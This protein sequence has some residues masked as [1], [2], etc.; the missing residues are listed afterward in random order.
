MVIPVEFPAQIKATNFRADGIGEHVHL[1][2]KH[3]RHR[4]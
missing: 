1:N 4:W 3:R 2:S